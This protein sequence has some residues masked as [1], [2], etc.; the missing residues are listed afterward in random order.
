[1]QPTAFKTIKRLG[2]L[3]KDPKI[4]FTVVPKQESQSK[5]IELFIT[6]P[7]EGF[8]YVTESGNPIYYRYHS[9]LGDSEGEDSDD[10]NDSQPFGQ[11]KFI[12]LNAKRNLLAMYADAEDK[13]RIIVMT[14]NLRTVLDDKET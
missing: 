8:H 13:G 2:D 14:A 4:E 11:V 5:K 10:A 9:E 3:G 12:A 1:M 7:V 6:D